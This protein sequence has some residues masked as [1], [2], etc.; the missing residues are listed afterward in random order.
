MRIMECDFCDARVVGLL[1]FHQSSA[2]AHTSPDSAYAL[3]LTGL[4]S[5]DITV[6]TIWEGES[7]MGVGALKWLAADH[8]EVKSMHTAESMR[9]RGA[10]SVM[11][12]HIIASARSMGMSRLSLQTGSWDYFRPAHALYRRHGFVECPPFADY[13]PDPNSLLMSLDLQ[14]S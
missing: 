2:H 5:P 8:G 12:R 13:A 11:L 6:W 14:T 1:Q 10:G 4:Q 9:G 7:L 3:D